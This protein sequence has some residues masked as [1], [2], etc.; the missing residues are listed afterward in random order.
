LTTLQ[1]RGGT[2]GVVMLTAVWAHLDEAQ[3]R[4]AMPNLAALLRR[5]GVLILSIRH[6][7]APANRCV[8]EISGE[9]TI[10]LAESCELRN[11]LRL[12]TESA[13]KVNRDAV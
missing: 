2:F 5:G 1:A 6:G 11:V 12:T 9:E 7:P 4:R 8:F 10:A 13:L 3:R